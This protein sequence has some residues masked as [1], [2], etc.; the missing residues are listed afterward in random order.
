M[1]GS[2]AKWLRIA[3]Q[4]APYAADLGLGDDKML[5]VA[6]EEKRVLVTRDVELA[7]RAEDAVLLHSKELDEQLV[8]TAKATGIALKP[9][10]ERCSLC[11]GE[12]VEAQD[13]DAEYV[14]EDADDLMVCTECGQFYWKGSHWDRIEERFKN[15]R[16]N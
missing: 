2:L 12:L 1:L 15:L 6:E 9:R 3:G 11:N 7:S 5:E 8:A 13:P 16:E 4:D 10:M 14:P